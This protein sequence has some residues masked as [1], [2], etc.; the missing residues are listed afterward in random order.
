MTTAIALPGISRT[1]LTHMFVRG[2]EDDR[3]V[4]ERSKAMADGDIRRIPG[5]GPATT[6]RR[7]A[8][9]A[10]SRG[11]VLSH[12]VGTALFAGLCERGEAERWVGLGDRELGADVGVVEKM[13]GDAGALLGCGVGPGAV[14]GAEGKEYDA[15]GLH[16]DG[17][18]VRV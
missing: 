15:A 13:P 18:R 2:L 14:R 4:V 7:R 16:L 1:F 11:V 10:L 8:V 17:H 6:K 12:N 9:L 3:Y 5:D